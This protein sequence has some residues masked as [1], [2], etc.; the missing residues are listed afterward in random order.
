M[1]ELRNVSGKVQLVRLNSGKEILVAPGDALPDS[2]SPEMRGNPR[3][4]RLTARALF[5]AEEKS[6]APGRR[7]RAGAKAAKPKDA[8]KADKGGSR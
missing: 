6:A 2:E 4:A 3:V 5:A 8:S 1:T 7:T